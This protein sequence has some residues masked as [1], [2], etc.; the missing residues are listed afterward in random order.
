[1]EKHRFADRRRL[2]LLI[3]DLGDGDS[4]FPVLAGARDVG[5]RMATDKA[6]L[7]ALEDHTT[8]A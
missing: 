4:V 5:K 2:E 8:I 3:D 1:M 7:A 6:E